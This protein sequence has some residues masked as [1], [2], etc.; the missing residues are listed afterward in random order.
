MADSGVFDCI[1]DAPRLNRRALAYL[2]TLPARAEIRLAALFYGDAAAE[3]HIASLKP[4]TAFLRRAAGILRAVAPTSDAPSL[5]RFVYAN[6]ADVARAAV[7][8]LAGEQEML[9]DLPARL[10]ALLTREDCFTLR[11]LKVSG[12]DAR[13]AGFTGAAIGRALEDVLFAV[14][15]GKIDN[16]RPAETEFLLSLGTKAVDREG[17]V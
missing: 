9:A 14:F 11:D 2:G 4:S 17:K 15:D 10:E 13:A 12:E 6:G 5:R 16:S 3:T 8:V 1:F 7:L